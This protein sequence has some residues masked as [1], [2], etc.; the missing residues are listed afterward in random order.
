MQNLLFML[1]KYFREV[2]IGILIIICSGLIY[3]NYE[4]KEKAQ[5]NNIIASNPEITDKEEEPKTISESKT[6]YVDIKGAVKKPGVYEVD[7]NSIIN[8]VIKLAGGFKTNAYKNNINLSKKVSDEMVIYVYTKTEYKNKSTSTKDEA[9]VCQTPTYEIDNCTCDQV[10]I[11]ENGSSNPEPN[12]NVDNN[13]PKDEVT[14]ININN[15]TVAD[16][17]T[18]SGIGEAKAKTIIDYRNENGN[19]KS[20][21]DLKNVSGIGESLLEKIKDYITV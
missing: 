5:A 4:A 11:I 10:S 20:I 19:F 7:N 3:Y 8:D 14:L 16:L 1:K 15:A 2:I 12:K 13:N 18:L 6:L 17:I 9:L 21:D